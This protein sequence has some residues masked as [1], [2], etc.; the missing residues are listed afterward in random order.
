[1]VRLITLGVLVGWS[2]LG[3]AAREEA[4]PERRAEVAARGAL[5]MP[6]DLAK[7]THRFESLPDGG[8]QTVS[9]LEPDSQQVRLIR[10]HLRQEA[11]RFSRGDFGD[12][13]AIHGHDM[14]GLAE[15]RRG[16]ARITVTFSELPTGAE[17][18]YQTSEPAL[19]TALHHWFAAQ[20]RDHGLGNQGAREPGSQGSL[21]P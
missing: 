7:T 1:M 15:L 6:F 14:P 13:A 2:V 5:V 4:S 16:A 19:L 10:E 3:C 12:P 21:V 11:E 20:R 17:L 18:R 8:R 9:A